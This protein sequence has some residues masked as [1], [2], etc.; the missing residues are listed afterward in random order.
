MWTAAIRKAFVDMHFRWQ[1]TL[2]AYAHHSIR[3]A[4]SGIVIRAKAMKTSHNYVACLILVF[5]SRIFL[6]EV[7]TIGASGPRCS[8]FESMPYKACDV[9]I[10]NGTRVVDALTL[11]KT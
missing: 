6:T 1:G 4:T 7:D 5:H 2:E 11:N 3:D 8:G 9:S 10:G